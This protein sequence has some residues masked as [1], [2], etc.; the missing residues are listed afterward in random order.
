M[1]KKVIIYGSIIL[2]IGIGVG[3]Y[4]AFKKPELTEDSFKE[5]IVVDE[6]PYNGNDVPQ[7]SNDED[8][9]TTDPLSDCFVGCPNGQIVDEFGEC[10]SYNLV[11]EP[12]VYVND[13][14]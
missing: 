14:E 11:D 1:N 10:S 5:Q 12:Y 2:A 6:I 9:D 4:F 13:Y 7:L 8:C 3:L